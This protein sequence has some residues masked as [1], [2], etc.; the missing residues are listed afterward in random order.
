MTRIYQPLASDFTVYIVTRKTGMPDG[1]TLTDMAD[2]YAEMIR[3]EFGGAI[4]VIGTS[5]GGS[6]AQH[7]AADH[8]ELLRRLVLHSSAYVLNDVAKKSQ[9][10]MGQLARQRDWM[11]LSAESIRFIVPRGRWFS[12]PAVWLGS[13][14]LS[15]TSPE[16][17]SDFITTVEAEDVHNFKDRLTE[18]MAP[19]LVIAGESDPF[20]NPELFQA[21]AEGIPNARIILYPGMGHP[22]NG[23]QFGE[24]VLRFLNDG[25]VE[26]LADS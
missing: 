17:P 18:I 20:Y 3:D 23:E 11:A 16:D 6:I 26:S 24:D 10:R 22:A 8:P 2:D 9:M 12:R 21:T 13:V 25:A 1:Y 15:L 7:F 19:T 5:T 14:F 4:D